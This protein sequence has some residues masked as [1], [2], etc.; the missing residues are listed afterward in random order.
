MA[1]FEEACSDL[2]QIESEIPVGWG[3]RGHAD[4]MPKALTKKAAI[5]PRVT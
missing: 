5:W 2:S 1:S 4:Q 3:A